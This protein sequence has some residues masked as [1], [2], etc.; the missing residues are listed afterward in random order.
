MDVLKKY[1]QVQEQSI[2]LRI[3]TKFQV[4]S[5]VALNYFIFTKLTSSKNS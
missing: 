5:F 3:K 2:G 4:L 1:I